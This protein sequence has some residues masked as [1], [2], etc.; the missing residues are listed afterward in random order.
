MRIQ[1]F[2]VLLLIHVI[3]CISQNNKYRTKAANNQLSLVLPEG[4][5]STKGSNGFINPKSASSILLFH[6]E[7]IGYLQYLDSLNPSY[8]EAQNLLVL[9]NETIKEPAL[10]GKLITCQYRV[11][12]IHFNRVFFVTGS[13]FETTLFLI[14]YPSA[15]EPEMYAIVRETIR[16]ISNEN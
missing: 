11:D 13:D 7:N 12:T 1:I 6:F 16:S 4:F 3:P 14:N 9:N 10:Y 5:N 15:M 8:F 2:I